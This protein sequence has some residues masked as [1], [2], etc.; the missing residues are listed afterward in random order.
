VNTRFSLAKDVATFLVVSVLETK[1]FC[2]IFLVAEDSFVS[3]LRDVSQHICIEFAKAY[4][5]ELSNGDF[6][7]TLKDLKEGIC[8]EDP[9]EVHKKIILKFSK[10]EEVIMSLKIV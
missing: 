7:K 9:D 8:K 3:K 2:G 1:I 4:D 10:F 6:I 5:K